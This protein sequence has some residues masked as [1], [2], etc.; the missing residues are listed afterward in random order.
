MVRRSYEYLSFGLGARA[1]EGRDLLR[2]LFNDVQRHG[3]ELKR[4]GREGMEDFAMIE[5]PMLK[6]GGI[7]ELETSSETWRGNA[8]DDTIV[9]VPRSVFPPTVG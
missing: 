7:E 8:L 6:I 9:A 3:L 4:Q 2:R 5:I 1:E